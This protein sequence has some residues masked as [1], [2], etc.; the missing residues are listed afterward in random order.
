MCKFHYL[1]IK[2][3]QL[4]DCLLID[5]LILQR[6]FQHANINVGDFLVAVGD[7]DTKRAKHDEVVTLVRKSGTHL[8]LRL[9]TPMNQDCYDAGGVA[10][11]PSTP[12]TPMKMAASPGHSLSG[13]SSKSGKSTG[14]RLSAPWIFAKRG[15]KDKEETGSR[16]DDFIL[17]GEDVSDKFS[18]HDVLM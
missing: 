18:D 3:D 12:K 17:L 11:V 16:N 4:I 1:E 15:N 14:S 2:F 8:V 9:I 5:D 6:M 7:V 10:S 13:A